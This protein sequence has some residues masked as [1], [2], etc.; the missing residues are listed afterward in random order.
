[1]CRFVAEIVIDGAAGS[2]DKYYTYAIPDSLL[3]EAKA[4][5]RVTV[6]F[7]KGNIKKQGM[8][9][10]VFKEEITPKTK[11]VLSVTDSDPILNGEMLKMCKWLKSQVFCTHFDA[12]HAML[13]AGL[14]YRLTDYYS[15]NQEFCS[16]A[17][18][19]ESERQIFEFLATTGEQPLKKLEQLFDNASDILNALYEKQAVTKNQV[20]IRRMQDITR[21]WVR[22]NT[23]NNEI[24]KLTARQQEIFDI[25][26]AAGSVSVKELQ[27]FTGVSASVIN[28]LEKKGLLISFEKQEFRLPHIN[29]QKICREEIVLTA[30]QQTAFDGLLALAR[31]QSGETAL[32]YGV[33]GS[34]KTKVF[35]KLVDEV[36]ARG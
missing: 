18:L 26:D 17:L 15:T 16:V 4:G 6:P 5:C 33:T 12:I 36:S 25:V 24:L 23:D 30:E 10:S 8:I 7:G 13:P 3:S 28:S 2:F 35:L 9:L 31:S 22:I 1:M 32:L 20:P 19:N 27:Y 11:E 21:R 14:N 34:G 29:T